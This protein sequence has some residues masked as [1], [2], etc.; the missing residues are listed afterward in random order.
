MADWWVKEFGYTVTRP[1]IQ[2]AST[3]IMDDYDC[4]GACMRE[5][6]GQNWSGNLKN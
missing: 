1:Q 4:D 2:L 6:D 3:A 5:V